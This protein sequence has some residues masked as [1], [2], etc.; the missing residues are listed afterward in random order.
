MKLGKAYLLACLLACLLADWLAGW[1]ACLLVVVFVV[2]FRVGS[3]EY[4]KRLKLML[5]DQTPE[6]VVFL[7]NREKFRSFRSVVGRPSR[8]GGLT[9]QYQ[10]QY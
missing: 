2:V 5:S 8:T 6:V 1:L 4:N 7:F 3:S 9:R 10:Y